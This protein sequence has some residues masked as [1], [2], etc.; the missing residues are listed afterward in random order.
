MSQSIQSGS[1]SPPAPSSR[2]PLPPM[3]IMG[4]ETEEQ[5]FL[6]EWFEEQVQNNMV[7]LEEGARHLSQLVTALF[8]VVFAVLAFAESPDIL[9]LYFVRVF[10]S[11]S[12]I[13]YFVSLLTALEVLH[14]WTS[15]FQRDNLT[16][17]RA[18]YEQMLARKANALNIALWSFVAGTAGLG[19]LVLAALWEW[20]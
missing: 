15:R 6:R 4:A 1:P 13:G 9:Q 16:E 2:P 11:V 5:R 14:P 10:G 20:G 12:V 8:G 3:E 18:L 17:M 7:Q 19:L